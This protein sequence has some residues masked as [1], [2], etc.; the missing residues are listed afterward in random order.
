LNKQYSKE[1]RYE[2]VDEIF[3]QM[4]KEPHPDPLLAG[5]GENAL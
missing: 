1:E 2:K 5:E 4:E 3:A